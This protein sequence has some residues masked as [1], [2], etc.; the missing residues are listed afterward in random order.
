M[1]HQLHTEIT[2]DSPPQI[3]WDLLVDL[4]TYRDWNPFIVSAEGVVAVGERLTNRLKS[5]GGKV[6]TFRPTVTVFEPAETFEWLGRLG[7]P[8]VFDG[9]HRFELHALPN[10]GTKLIHSEK[11]NGLLVRPLRRSLD[12][13]TTQGFE[14]M[15]AALKTKAEAATNSG[16]ESCS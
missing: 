4:G 10:G 14:A 9:R 15:N 3:V 13:K 16:R 12:T 1:R 11:L 8:G 6:M 7:M 5:P 2:I